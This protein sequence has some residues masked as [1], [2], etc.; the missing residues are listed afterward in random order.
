MKRGGVL[1]VDTILGVPQSAE[2]SPLPLQNNSSLES[3][4]APR[5]ALKNAK[6]RSSSLPEAHFVKHFPAES[7]MRQPRCPLHRLDGNQL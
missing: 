5:K 7:E 1:P 2:P 4:G 3:K 6:A